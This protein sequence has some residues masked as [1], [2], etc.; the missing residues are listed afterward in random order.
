VVIA[1]SGRTGCRQS[2]RR[3]GIDNR[4]VA[5]RLNLSPKTVEYYL[6][7]IYRKLRITSRCQLPGVLANSSPTTA[8]AMLAC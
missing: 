5:A 4:S 7:C 6:G 3:A 1:E 8:E 2:C